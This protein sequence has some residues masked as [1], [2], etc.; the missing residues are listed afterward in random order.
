MASREASS[1]NPPG[2]PL[3]DKTV[4]Y[5]TR[6][7]GPYVGFTARA[8]LLQVGRYANPTTGECGTTQERIAEE[9]ECSRQQVKRA[10]EKLEA[11]GIIT[12][13]QMDGTAGRRTEYTLTAAANGWTP[14]P[15]EESGAK[16]QRRI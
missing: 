16:R 6:H 15:K 11:A 2:D 13:R 7:T 4:A 12:C 5:Y 14:L 3:D 1:H 8:V 9:L 10:F